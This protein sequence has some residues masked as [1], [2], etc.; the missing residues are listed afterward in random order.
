M[1]EQVQQFTTFHGNLLEAMGGSPEN[2]ISKSFIVI[3][4][5]SNDI[6]EYFVLNRTQTLEEFITTLMENYQT[7]L[8]VMWLPSYWFNT[9]EDRCNIKCDS[10]WAVLNDVGHT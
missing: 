10:I 2:I 9:K 5:G 4:V 3:S 8:K 6:F 1:R 7:D